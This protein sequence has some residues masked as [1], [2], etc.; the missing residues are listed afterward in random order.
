MLHT[1]EIQK[2]LNENGSFSWTIETVKEIFDKY[3]NLS[4]WALTGL[5]LR[6]KQEL[7][8]D[9]KHGLEVN[10]NDSDGENL[11]HYV[12]DGKTAKLLIMN[13]ADVNAKSNTLGRT[14]LHYARTKEVAEI[15][16]LNGADVNARS[17]DGQTP[18]HLAKDAEIARVLLKNGADVNA[19]IE[20][21]ITA[22]RAGLETPLHLAR[23]A[24]IAETLLLHGADVN[25][26]SIFGTPLMYAK[27]AAI[28]E[29]LLAHGADIKATD[30]DGNHILS[31]SLLIDREN[32]DGLD[33]LKKVLITHGAE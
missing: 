6:E 15:L 29:I 19:R 12:R 1:V 22:S 9:I 7:E 27:N 2:R 33:E 10:K 28:A 13:G 18:L 25:S 32:T 14:P 17:E 21:D 3:P 31:S 24:E 30:C 16:L 8:D 5:F 26:Y 20:Y 4:K 11:L 23:N